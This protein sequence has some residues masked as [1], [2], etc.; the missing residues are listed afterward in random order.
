MIRTACTS[1]LLASLAFAKPKQPAPAP[2]P[3]KDAGAPA[4]KSAVL[5][6]TQGL[7]TP[8][9]ALYDAD[10]DTYLVTNII[11]SPLAK[12]GKAAIFEISPA[13]ETVKAL[14]FEGK[15]KD[16][17]NAPKGMALLGGVLYVADIDTV[18]TYERKTFKSLGE[19]KVP[20]ATFLND[21]SAGPDGK[22]YLSDSGL[23]QGAKDFEPSGTD[24]LYVIEPG[25]K[26]VL[27]TLL[28]S[29]DLNKPNG[30]LATADTLYVVTFGSNE[31]LTFDLKGKKKAEPVKLPKGS[32][33]GIV[34]LPGGDLL[35]SSWDGK[36]LYRGKPAG[37]FTELLG[38]LNAP[39][40]IGY[41][42]KRM[43]VLVPRF[44]DNRLEAWDVDL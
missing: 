34:L 1:L 42:S 14:I 41:D 18:R 33:D 7:S 39:A 12:D 6:F 15:D 38:D 29:K 16:D 37:P 32:L 36:A 31:L 25:K 28:K 44:L 23:K 24:G 30:V 13:G 19:V 26:P 10:T 17:L 21:L 40:D 11:G 27:K 4:K 35:I 9:S 43:R 20:G 8:E 3:A 5:T 2:A 22:V